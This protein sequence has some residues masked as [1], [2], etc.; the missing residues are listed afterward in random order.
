MK[1]IILAAKQ[2]QRLEPFTATRAK[3]MIFIAGKMILETTILN[4]REAGIREIL[5]VVN[6]Q[7]EQIQNF[8]TLLLSDNEHFR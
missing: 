7:H 3:P 5:I 2:S 1:A 4:L 8:E 6:H